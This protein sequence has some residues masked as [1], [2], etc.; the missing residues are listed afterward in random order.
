MIRAES[1]SDYEL[2]KGGGCEPAARRIGT[3]LNE[4]GISAHRF[5]HCG[6]TYWWCWDRYGCTTPA[7]YAA[8]HSVPGNYLVNYIYPAHDM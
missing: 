8:N 1:V 4:N 3:G 5:D 2:E 6:L 7:T